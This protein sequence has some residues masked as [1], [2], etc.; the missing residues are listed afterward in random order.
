[1]LHIF[2]I[3]LVKLVERE[4][5][6]TLFWGRREQLVVVLVF[7]VAK[8]SG[9][10]LVQCTCTFTVS[11]TCVVS[12]V[13][14]AID[15]PENPQNARPDSR[16]KGK[17]IKDM[18]CRCLLP[19]CVQKRPKLGDANAEMPNKRGRRRSQPV[20][21]H[22]MPRNQAIDGALDRQ[23]PLPAETYG[24]LVRSCPMISYRPADRSRSGA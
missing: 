18:R 6:T 14:P 13:I 7:H 23:E 16:T 12:G 22:T 3:N 21:G 4:P 15:R 9:S 17:A 20:A 10:R 19:V 1:M 11:I 5:T 8:K 24:V 2:S